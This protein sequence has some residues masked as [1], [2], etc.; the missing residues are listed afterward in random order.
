MLLGMF[1]FQCKSQWHGA[2]VWDLCSFTPSYGYLAVPL[3]FDVGHCM[4]VVH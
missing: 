3:G 2:L 4:L 1:S